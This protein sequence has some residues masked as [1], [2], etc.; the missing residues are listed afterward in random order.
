[1]LPIKYMQFMIFRFPQKGRQN[2][3]KIWW[4]FHLFFLIN[5]YITANLYI[6]FDSKENFPE[7]GS[8]NISF[9]KIYNIVSP[10]S[11]TNTTNPEMVATINPAQENHQE[12]QEHQELFKRTLNSRRSIVVRETTTISKTLDIEMQDL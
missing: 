11:Q 5:I 8:F 7:L 6:Y 10:L 1:M 3:F 12:H 4:S 2:A 9:I